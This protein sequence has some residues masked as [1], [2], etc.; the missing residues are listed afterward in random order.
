M[1]PPGRSWRFVPWAELGR[2]ELYAILVLRSR[3]FVVEQ[4]CPYLDPDGLDPACWHLWTA[5]PEARALAYTRVVP[6]GAKY[7]E[8]S[9]GRV[10]TAPE[11]RMLNGQWIE[12]QPKC[13]ELGLLADWR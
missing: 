10:V 12:A 11:A 5:G 6:P 4:T 2:D 7:A 3:V 13:R 8:A 1:D 9:L